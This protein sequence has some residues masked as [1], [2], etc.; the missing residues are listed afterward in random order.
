M[1][2][3]PFLLQNKFPNILERRQIAYYDSVVL[4]GFIFY[5]LFFILN[6]LEAKTTLDQIIGNKKGT[7]LYKQQMPS[8]KYLKDQK[9]H[10][11]Q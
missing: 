10:I 5:Y 8:Y 1:K 6:M 3:R 9:R 11:W 7:K 2:Q 4:F